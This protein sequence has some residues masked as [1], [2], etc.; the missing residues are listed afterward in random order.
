MGGGG[1]TDAPAQTVTWSHKPTLLLQN[2]ESRLKIK[3]GLRDL[4]PPPPLTLLGNRSLNTLSRQRT[5]NNGSAGGYVF[6]V[7]RVI[8]G[9][10]YVVRGSLTDRQTVGR[11]VTQTQV[12]FHLPLYY[13]FYL[14]MCVKVGN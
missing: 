11:S 8:P 1:Y 3:G 4:W 5:Y 7:V 9:I 2:K 10:Q 14:C 6:C 13:T 12:Y